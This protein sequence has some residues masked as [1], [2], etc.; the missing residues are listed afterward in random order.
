MLERVLVEADCAFNGSTRRGELKPNFK[1]CPFSDFTLRVMSMR[2]YMRMSLFVRLSKKKGYCETTSTVAVWRSPWQ[3][4]RTSSKWE[5]RR[6]E[7]GEQ[8]HCLHDSVELL[9]NHLNLLHYSIK[10]L[11]GRLRLS[12]EPEATYR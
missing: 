3:S 2:M 5:M 8:S 12:E 4:F 1:Y 9:D 10:T 6:A 11:A 7:Y